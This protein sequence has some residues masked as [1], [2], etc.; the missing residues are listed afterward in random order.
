MRWSKIVGYETPY[1]VTGAVQ[2][3]G[4]KR[5]PKDICTDKIIGTWEAEKPVWV[6]RRRT[7]SV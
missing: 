6:R 3:A 5:T 1:S 7:I 2:Y 4:L